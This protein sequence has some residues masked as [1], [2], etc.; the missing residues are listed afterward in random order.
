V[1]FAGSGQFF[2]LQ[3]VNEN[4]RPGHRCSPSS[5]PAEPN[6]HPWA[7]TPIKPPL[8]SL[9]FAASVSRAV[10]IKTDVNFFGTF[11]GHPPGPAGA[12]MEQD[13]DRAGRPLEHPDLRP[14][15]L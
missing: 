7:V 6:L 3:L 15:R 13:E 4:F 12:E 2:R 5:R 9:F 11:A 8:T 1:E 14:E 10:M